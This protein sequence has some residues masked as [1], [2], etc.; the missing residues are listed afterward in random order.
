L[1]GLG[2]LTWRRS[3]YFRCFGRIVKNNRPKL[4]EPTLSAQAPYNAEDFK[5][6]TKPSAWRYVPIG[7]HLVLEQA[8]LPQV[9]NVQRSIW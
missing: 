1:T 5:R 7:F 8:V 6:Y 3:V 2:Y 4:F 9:A